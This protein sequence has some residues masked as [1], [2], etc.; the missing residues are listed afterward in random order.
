ML[1]IPI[2]IIMSHTSLIPHYFW[3]LWWAKLDAGGRRTTCL[4]TT[5]THGALTTWC[6]TKTGWCGCYQW[7]VCQSWDGQ[8]L[9]T[10]VMVVF[11][12]GKFLQSYYL[13]KCYGYSAQSAIMSHQCKVYIHMGPFICHNASLFRIQNSQLLDREILRGEQDFLTSMSSFVLPRNWLRL[14]ESINRTRKERVQ[15]G[16]VTQVGRFLLGSYSWSN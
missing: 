9:Q 15:K 13:M 1:S 10:L 8:K 7:R 2:S 4:W 5:T 3:C 16:D 11:V 12:L 6:C 14:Q